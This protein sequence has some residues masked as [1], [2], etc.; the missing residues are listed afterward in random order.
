[1]DARQGL[2]VNLQGNNTSLQGVCHPDTFLNVRLLKTH[3]QVLP[4][5][6]D[7][8][9]LGINSDVVL[10]QD[11]RQWDAGEN[12]VGY[13]ALIPRCSRDVFVLITA[14]ARAL[15]DHLM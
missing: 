13:A 2:A 8:L 12:D 15:E 9:D 11:C 6:G 14:V 10:L 3:G 5:G 1:M 4:L 7:K